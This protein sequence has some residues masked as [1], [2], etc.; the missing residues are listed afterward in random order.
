M[1]KEL[2]DRLFEKRNKTAVTP[3]LADQI[4]H[5]FGES[6]IYLSEYPDGLKEVQRPQWS[7]RE[8]SASTAAPP[9]S[10]L[11]QFSGL[12]QPW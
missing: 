3:A 12:R 7:N 11:T 8:L 1:R 9:A 10:L 6:R 5:K 4:K 2:E